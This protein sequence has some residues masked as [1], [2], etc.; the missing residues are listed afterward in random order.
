MFKFNMELNLHNIYDCIVQYH[1]FTI[2]GSVENEDFF[3]KKKCSINKIKL[4]RV[5]NSLK[6]SCYPNVVICGRGFNVHIFRQLQ[7]KE[8]RSLKLINL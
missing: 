3:S 5:E 6:Y 8:W 4:K 7:K 1:N 2:V